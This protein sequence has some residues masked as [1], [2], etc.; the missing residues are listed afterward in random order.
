MTVRFSNSITKILDSTLTL[1]KFHGK[2]ASTSAAVEYGLTPCKNS[3]FVA[4]VDTEKYV[5]HS[6]YQ[7]N[8][9]LQSSF[10]FI[11]AKFQSMALA[12]SGNKAIQTFFGQPH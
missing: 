5:T 3:D 4:V 10:Q 2:D 1:F 9:C 11:T 6:S 12:P 7:S 8:K